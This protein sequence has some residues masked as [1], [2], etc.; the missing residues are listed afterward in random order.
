MRRMHR[1]NR[2]GSAGEALISQLDNA[3]EHPGVLDELS[4]QLMKST[5]AMFRVI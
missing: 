4:G 3:F 2:S 1:C 5:H